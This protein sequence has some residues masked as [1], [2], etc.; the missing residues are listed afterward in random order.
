MFGGKK[1]SA[2]IDLVNWEYLKKIKVTIFKGNI[3]C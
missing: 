3:S 2:I 1:K